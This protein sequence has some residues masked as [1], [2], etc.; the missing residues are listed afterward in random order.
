M[1]R[2][3]HRAN[4]LSMCN[5]EGL[6]GENLDEVELREIMARRLLQAKAP[7]IFEVKKRGRWVACG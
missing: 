3:N 7:G 4:V 5:R 6:Q 2:G 1:K